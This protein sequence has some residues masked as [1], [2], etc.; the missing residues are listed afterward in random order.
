MNCLS[1]SRIIGCL[2][3]ILAALC[4][5]PIALGLRSAP[6]LALHAASAT[7]EL[8]GNGVDDD[9]NGKVDDVHGELLHVF[10]G[11]H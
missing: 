1:I 2:Q 11:A 10:L 7:G 4:L 8:P 3:A 6:I 5:P 9:N